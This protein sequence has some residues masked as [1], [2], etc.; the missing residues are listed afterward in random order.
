[1]KISFARSLYDAG[2][3]P[4]WSAGAAGPTPT[5]A[6]ADFAALERVRAYVDS[7]GRD[8]TATADLPERWLAAWADFRDRF[9]GHHAAAEEGGVDLSA[10]RSYA[11]EAR[12]WRASFEAQGGRSTS[13][14]DSA[15]GSATR[16]LPPATSSWSFWKIAAAVGAL[17]GGVVLIRT[18]SG[19]EEE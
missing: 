5:R 18:R 17:V 14:P 7:L 2:A 15:P 12:R 19:G 13:L 11:D 9:T 6:S 3:G 8:V 16:D 1:M 10:L 4:G